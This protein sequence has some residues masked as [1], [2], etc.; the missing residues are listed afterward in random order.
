MT[1][2]YHKEIMTSHPWTFF[3]LLFN[4]KSSVWKAVSVELLVWLII[5]AIL[6]VIYRTALADWQ[7]RSFENV[8]L[9]FENRMSYF[10]LDLVLGFYIKLNVERWEYR[11]RRIG[12][13]DNPCLMVAE[14]VR[15]HSEMGRQ[16]RRTIIRYCA[17]GQIMIFRD[18]SLRCRRRFPTLDSIVQQGFMTEAEKMEFERYNIHYKQWICFNWA[19]ALVYEA[20]KRGLIKSDIFTKEV[21]D[22]LKEFR[23]DLEWCNNYDWQPIPLLYSHVVCLAVHFYFAIAL[24]ARQHV[25]SEDNPNKIQIDIYFPLMPALQFVFYIGWMKIAE[26]M[27][28]PFGEDDDDWEVNALIDRNINMGMAIVDGGFDRPPELRKDPFWDCPVWEP[29]YAENSMEDNGDGAKGMR[30]SASQANFHP[31]GEIRMVS[32]HGRKISD[33]HG[34]KDHAM[35]VWDDPTDRPIR[36]GPSVLSLDGLRNI[37]GQIQK[38]AHYSLKP[39]GNGVASRKAENGKVTDKMI[40]KS[41]LDARAE[42]VVG[43]IIAEPTSPGLTIFTLEQAMKQQLPPPSVPKEVSPPPTFIDFDEIFRAGRF[44]DADGAPLP[45]EEIG[46]LKTEHLSKAEENKKKLPKT[47]GLPRFPL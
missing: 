35:T 18:I 6:S 19:Y 44:L 29:L 25:I 38:T 33:S 32:L 39:D 21:V 8:V 2:N 46:E 9:W 23:T 7:M 41:R 10:P 15:G 30:G 40:P 37:R 22:Q 27:I 43:E 28:N 47:Y 5:Y 4:W 16:F 24:I 11:Y 14:Y 1:L 36:K 45:R 3:K 17:L 31:K 20:R 34:L 42:T 13:I 26:M 12:Y